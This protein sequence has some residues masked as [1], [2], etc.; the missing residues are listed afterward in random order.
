LVTLNLLII[1]IKATISLC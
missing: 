1:N